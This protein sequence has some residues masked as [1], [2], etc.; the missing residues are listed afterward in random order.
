M[1][2][3][4]ENVAYSG[5]GPG[6]EQFALN[7]GI[8]LLAARSSAWGGGSVALQMLGP[9]GAT[10]LSV[11]LNGAP[12]QLTADGTVSPIWLPPGQYQLVVATATGVDV[13]LASV[14][15]ATVL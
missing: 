2:V 13:K 6:S 9:D 15:P 12:V 4:T 7:G 10:Y 11:S 1:G 8:Y 3:Q 14:P 5:L